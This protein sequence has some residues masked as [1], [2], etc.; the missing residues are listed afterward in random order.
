MPK[1]E[2][3]A[4]AG[5]KP[6]GSELGIRAGNMKSEP[7]GLKALTVHAEVHDTLGHT[8]GIGGHAAIGTVVA[9]PGAHDGD[10]G[11]VGADVDIVCGVGIKEGVV[12]E[13]VLLPWHCQ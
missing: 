10:D 2:A 11:A 6:G 7:T 4:E 3:V 8:I 13:G 1:R 9:G 5:F 12:S